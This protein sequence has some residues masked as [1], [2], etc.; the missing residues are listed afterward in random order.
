MSDFP[1]TV[2]QYEKQTTS[3]EN[4]VALQ[5]ILNDDA[6]ADHGTPLVSDDEFRVRALERRLAERE[7][8]RRAAA[9]DKA[10]HAQLV[11]KA[12][13]LEILIAEAEEASRIEYERIR[14]SFNQP[15]PDPARPWRPRQI[16]DAPA[17]PRKAAHV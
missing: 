16:W 13:M 2:E 12:A 15:P 11:R 5:R 3:I 9:G 4:Q 14:A 10:A 1:W 7:L 17:P 8:R 6:H